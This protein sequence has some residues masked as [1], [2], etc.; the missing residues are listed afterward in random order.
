MW[1]T[2]LETI[3]EADLLDYVEGRMSADDRATVARRLAQEPALARKCDRV[4][5]QTLNVRLLR[6]ILP[7]EGVP[8]EWLDLLSKRSRH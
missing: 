5:E 2:R 8:Q 4:R 7:V 6:S 3:T 1:M